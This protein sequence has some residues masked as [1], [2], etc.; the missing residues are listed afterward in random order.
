MIALFAVTAAG[1]RAADE[2][3]AALGASRREL[4]ELPALWPE[5]DGAVLDR[6]KQTY[7]DLEGDLEGDS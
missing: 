7:L 2:V 6:L 1:R 5:L 4:A 3:A